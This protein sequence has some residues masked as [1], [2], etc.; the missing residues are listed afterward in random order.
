VFF[1]ISIVKHST[2]PQQ[3]SGRQHWWAPGT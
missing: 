1:V 3:R 2:F